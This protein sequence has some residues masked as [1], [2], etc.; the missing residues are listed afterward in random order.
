MA[1][2]TEAEFIERAGRIAHD[3]AVSKK[4][5]NDLSEK[6]AR[7]DNL[8]PDEI[9]TL[10]RLANVATF[11][12]LFKRK[13]DGDK[14]VE[15]ESGDP[16]AVINRIVTAAQEAPQSANIH[17]DK[18]ASLWTAPDMM[19]AKR[20]GR[21]FDDPAQEKLASDSAP[22]PMRHDLAVL[23]LRKLAEEFEIER[24]SAGQ[25]WETLTDKLAAT[26][27]RAPGYGP[28]FGEFEKDA[29]ADVGDAAQP[30]LHTV[31]ESLRLP[32]EPVPAEKIAHFQNHRVVEDTENLR[33]LKKAMAAREDYN[34]FTAGLKWI[35]DNMPSLGR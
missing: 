25:R 33:L 7:D 23:A 16:E 9:R 10:V 5:L 27:R 21:A 28:S 22:A 8:Q 26:F 31:R 1:R 24:I 12:E 34:H 17:N 35:E 30:E 6:V 15:F 20:L 14:M 3:H 29:Y 13:D 18:L 2:W 4:P 19:V 32:A 11:Q